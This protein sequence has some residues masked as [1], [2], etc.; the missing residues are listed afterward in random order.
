MPDAK[1]YI[2]F[3]SY[4]H[5]DERWAKRLQRWLER[6]RVPKRLRAERPEL[7]ARLYPVFRDRDELASANDLSESIQSAMADSG[8][9]IVICS[10]TAAASRWVNEEIRH[11]RQNHDPKRIF[12]LMVAGQPNPDA[13]DCAFPPALLRDDE[14]ERLHEPLAADVTASGDGP[15]NAALKIAAGLLGVGVDELKQ[16]DAQR[17]ARFWSAVAAG[18]LAVAALTIGLAIVAVLAREESELRRQQAENLIGFMLG[19]LRGK[20]QPIGK[21]DVLDAVGDQAMDYFAA[22]GER[23]SDREMLARAMA[24]RQIGEVRFNQ[25]KLEPAL[26][27]FQ[28]SLDQARTLYEHTPQNDD[29]LFE[30]GQAEF[31]VGYVAWQRNDLDGAD[32]AFQRYMQRSRELLAREPDNHDYQLELSYAY[33]NLG[34]MARERGRAETALEHFEMSEALLRKLLSSDPSDTGIRFDLAEGL[35]WIGSTLLDLGRLRESEKTFRE[36]FDLF[37]SLHELQAD[38][39]HSHKFGDAGIFLA[40]VSLHLGQLDETAE[41][42]RSSERINQGLVDFDP[43]NSAWRRALHSG[44]R[45]QAELALATGQTELADELLA[46]AHMGF[47]RLVEEDPSNR[48]LAIH[49]AMTERAQALRLLGAGQLQEALSLARRATDRIDTAAEAGGRRTARLDSALIAESLGRIEQAAGS[50]DASAASL[51]KA[52]RLLDESAE[53]GVVVNALR[54]QL[55]CYLNREEEA[56]EL[57][58]RLRA[59]GFADPRFPIPCADTTGVVTSVSATPR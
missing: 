46:M 35:S 12:C 43:T 52:Q 54:A 27:A 20:L 47:S 37:S 39:L 38:R 30:L 4:S 5:A 2:A 10:P 31:W 59:V 16:R 22:L 26:A 13:P 29:Y 56:Q 25:G 23:G 55:A 1:R 3:I 32:E 48:V 28:Q 15:R 49:L 42:F 57:A 36:A 21:L 8:A 33:G 6:Y 41:L 50:V 18:S 51:I 14:G 11:F 7:P 58:D 19:D 53:S 44:Q 45:F 9:L 17:Q 40:R 34:S 24:L